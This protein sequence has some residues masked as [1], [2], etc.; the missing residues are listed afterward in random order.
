MA[1]KRATYYVYG[2]DDTCLDIQ[3][4][5]ED[6]G[7]ILSVR[8]MKKDPLTEAELDRLLGHLPLNHFINPISPGFKARGLDAAIPDRED[9]FRI[10]A[11][12]PSLLR[13][14]I[15]KTVRLLTVG[16]DKKKIAEMLQFGRENDTGPHENHGRRNG[17][18]ATAASGK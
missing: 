15:L 3:K 8:D 5:I 16:C 12:D 6:A 11:E 2:S 1:Q 17:S 7:V 10:L 13:R 18:R 4:Y 9:M 14:P